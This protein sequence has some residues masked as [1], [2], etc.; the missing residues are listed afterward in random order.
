MLRNTHYQVAAVALAIA[1]S[2]VS[3]AS[4]KDH[5]IR[6]RC[7]GDMPGGQNWIQVTHN[8][9]QRTLQ[10]D[11]NAYPRFFFPSGTEIKNPRQVNVL[12]RFGTEI[13]VTYNGDGKI[14]QIKLLDR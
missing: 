2:A 13:E 8:G 14:T 11:N 3:I 7:R 4:A 6:C 12:V 5:K 1:L 9:E 10:F